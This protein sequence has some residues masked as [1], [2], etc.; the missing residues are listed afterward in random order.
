MM[1]SAT[2]REPRFSWKRGLRRPDV[3]RS[4]GAL[5]LLLLAACSKDGAP[6]G[7]EDQAPA[8]TVSG[9]TDGETREGPVTITISIDVG[10]YQAELNGVLF[11]SGRAVSAPGDYVLR[12]TA[13]NGEAVSALEVRF[14][15]ALSGETQLIVRFF[16]LGDNDVG[17]GGDAILLTDSSGVGSRHVLIDAGPSGTAGTDRGYVSRRLQELGVDTLEA[18]ILSHA[19]ADHFDGMTTILQSLFVRRF[20]YNGQVRNFSPYNA[21]I[22]QAGQRAGEVT[23]PSTVVELEI[24]FGGVRTR[25]ATVPPLTTFLTKPDADGTELNEGSLGAEVGKGAFRMLLAGDAEVLAN[26]RWRTQFPVRTGDVNI[27]KLG[28]HGANDATFDNGFNGN[29]TWLAHTNPEVAVISANGTTHP[30]RNAIAQLLTLSETRTYCTNVHG[31]IE[32]RIGE[33]GRFLVTVQ[34]NRD[35]ECVAGS[36][37]DS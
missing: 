16:N 28:H 33:D 27:L 2:R 21:V 32:I 11:I 1:P 12:V 30:R 8:I 18:L 24:G 20:V 37:A 31:D 35:A 26:Q 9:I 5:V 29:S 34:R 25:L 17:G 15:I 7:P 4:L 36:D 23:T 3:L 10:T 22:T 19:H 6:A 14:T 13:R